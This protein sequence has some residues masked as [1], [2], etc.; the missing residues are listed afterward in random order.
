MLIEKL[1]H[2]YQFQLLLSSSIGFCCFPLKKFVEQYFVTCLRVFF[3]GE[4]HGKEFIAMKGKMIYT[5]NYLETQ[6]FLLYSTYIISL[7]PWFMC[8]CLLVVTCTC[9]KMF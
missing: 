3:W 1:N 9:C 5:W 2:A 6:N 7:S 8:S 4:K